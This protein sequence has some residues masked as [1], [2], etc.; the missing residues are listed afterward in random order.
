MRLPLTCASSNAAAWIAPL[1]VSVPA[2]IRTRCPCH[3]PALLRSPAVTDNSPAVSSDPD[4][5]LTSDSNGA[6]I[7][8]REASVS[9]AIPVNVPLLVML[10]CRTVTWLPWTVPLLRSAVPVRRRA[11]AANR[12]PR[13][14]VVP[15]SS[16]I[17]SWLI[18]SP[19]LLSIPV[20]NAESEPVASPLPL[21]CQSRALTPTFCPCNWPAVVSVVPER[22][23]SPPVSVREPASNSSI[24]PVSDRVVS[25]CN[26]P[27]LV[28]RSAFSVSELPA[29]LPAFVRDCDVI[30]LAPCASSRPPALL[31]SVP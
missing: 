2:L 17:L 31:F 25:P 4:V 1:F 18:R 8:G 20:S 16:V 21:C 13:L 7:S 12:L 14:S 11:S 5:S 24:P 19:V 30:R 6:A 26:R 28:R 9:A 27:E 10:S 23:R 29:I 3:C 22:V 15:V